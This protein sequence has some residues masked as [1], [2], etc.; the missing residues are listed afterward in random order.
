[1][2]VSRKLPPSD[3]TAPPLCGFH[4]SYQRHQEKPKS[5]HSLS[6]AVHSPAHELTPP[7]HSI[8]QQQYAFLKKNVDHIKHAYSP[9][10]IP[11]SQFPFWNQKKKNS[12]RPLL[13]G[14]S[15]MFLYLRWVSPMPGPSP[16]HCRAAHLPSKNTSFISSIHPATL[17][18]L[19]GM[20]YT[21]NGI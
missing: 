5:V 13:T 8:P 10:L 6:A 1:M 20:G 11:T 3:C 9:V 18:S 21:I 19:T 12:M 17:R 16:L 2:V 14:A 7:A 4:Y 15:A